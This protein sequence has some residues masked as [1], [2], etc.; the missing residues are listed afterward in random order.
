MGQFVTEGAGS[1]VIITDNGYIVTNNHVIEDA[2]RITVLLSSGAEYDARLIGR[3]SANDLAVV[4]INA[5]GLHPAVYGD[6]DDLVVG[7]IAVAIGNPLGKL[8]G[9]VSEGIISALSRNIDI[10]GHSMNLLQTTA[11]VNPGNSGGGLFNRFGELIGIVNAKS[12]GSDIEGLGFA[13]PI[14][15]VKSIADDLIEYGYIPGR[16]DLGATLIDILDTRTA[17]VYRVQTLGVY[18]LEADFDAELQT[19]D[20]IVSV[21]GVDIESI[22]DIDE[23][24]ESCKVGDDL[25]ITL[26]R[27]GGSITVMQTLKQA[28]S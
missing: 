9:T 5:T 28:M 20:R 3:D 18:V 19:G 17:M 2:S 27:N 13:I 8:G 12:S 22:A 26:V 25:Q 24:L 4:K 1:G 16:I 21:N 23:I 10:D 15:T 6:S 14:N 7:E 11:A